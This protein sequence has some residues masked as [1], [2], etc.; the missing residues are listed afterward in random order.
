M[1]QSWPKIFWRMCRIRCFGWIVEICVFVL[2]VCPIR[3]MVGDYVGARR[4][5]VENRSKMVDM[6]VEWAS[7]G[8]R[9]GWSVMYAVWPWWKSLVISYAPIN[10]RFK[11]DGQ[12][13]GDGDGCYLTSKLWPSLS[14]FIKFR[15]YKNSG[16]VF[17]AFNARRPD[18]HSG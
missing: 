7:R 16:R 10:P 18:W 13:W 5:R 14:R 15:G 4:A 3:W 8:V 9:G 12:G 6:E 11:N 17:D 2:R 1:Y